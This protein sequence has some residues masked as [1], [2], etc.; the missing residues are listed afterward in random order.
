M[1]KCEICERETE[2]EYC[3]YHQAASQNLQTAFDV[4]R[5]ALE[6]EW[7][8]YLVS[9]LATEELGVWVRDVITHLMLRDSSSR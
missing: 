6:I 3:S 7:K 4:W 2:A 5:N 1:N 8:E 9:L